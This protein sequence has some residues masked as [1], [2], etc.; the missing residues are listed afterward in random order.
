M[1][2]AGTRRL[3]GQCSSSPISAAEAW[4]TRT[5]VALYD[6][7]P[8]KRLEVSGPGAL[9]LLQRLSTGHIAKKPGAVTYCLLLNP[10][11]RHPQRHHHRPAQ[12]RHASSSA[13]TATSTS[14]TSPGRPATR[15]RPTPASVGAGPRHHRR[16]LLHRPLG[17]AGPGG[18]GQGQRAT[19]SPTTR[20]RYFRTKPRWSSAAIPVT[21][22]R[23]SYVGELGWELYTSAE[24]RTEALGR[25][26]RGRPASSGDHR[27]RPRRLQLPAPGKG[28][29]AL[30]HRHDARARPVSKRAS[31]SPS[32]RTRRPSSGPT[33]ST[34]RATSPRPCG[35]AA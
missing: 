13:P 6:M 30:G 29:P 12:R 3:G 2:A 11:R 10:R 16:H 33:R 23:L 7:T 26:L 22:M 31:A 9:T 1:A 19:I 27:R 24:T 5:A 21:A 32:P 25:A 18:H 34:G 20:L 28:L 35:C 15:P 14:T 8:L 17:A 4:K